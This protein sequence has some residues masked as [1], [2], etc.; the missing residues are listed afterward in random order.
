MNGAGNVNKYTQE[1][2]EKLQMQLKEAEM[3][4]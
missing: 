1:E 2:L 4:K 3:D